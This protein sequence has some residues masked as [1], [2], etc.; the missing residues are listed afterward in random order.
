MADGDRCPTVKHRL[1]EIEKITIKSDEGG[2]KPE[3]VNTIAQE[4][5]PH[6]LGEKCNC[7]VGVT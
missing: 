1:A 2:S 4:E 7:P 6:S 3:R 5:I